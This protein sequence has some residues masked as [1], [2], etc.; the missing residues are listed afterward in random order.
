MICRRAARHHPMGRLLGMALGFLLSGCSA[1]PWFGGEEDPRPP[2]ELEE[3]QPTLKVDRLWVRKIG[4]GTEGRR[5][6]LAPAFQEGQLFIADAK[7][8]VSAIRADDGQVRWQRETGLPYSGGP[9]VAG[10]ALIL[11][12]IDGDLVALSSQ[13][14]QER[15]RIQLASEVLS[16]PKIA[17]ELVIV[18]SLDDQVFG[19]D[20]NT[21]EP[22]WVYAS[23][24]PILSLRGSSAPLI[25]GDAV[26]V[27]LSGGRLV[28]LELATGL[29]EWETT[30]TPPRGRS[31]LARVVD[32]DATPVLDH[33]TL[34][35]CAYNGDLAAVDLESGAV[36]W[37]RKLSAH[38]GLAMADGVLY[39]TDSDDQI[40]AAKPSDGA[41]LWKQD[42]LRYRNLSAPA[43]LGDWLILGD[44]AGYVHWLSR[45]D[46]KLVARQKIADAPIQARPLVVGERVFVYASDGTLAALA[47]H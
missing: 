3:I 41:G 40:W 29:P 33:G 14:G 26:I 12:S 6:G 23:Q 35:V 15:W 39:V 20:L 36:L 5:L 45:A 7:G 8:L 18:H 17:G 27:G 10:D 13:D 34:Y 37:R 19:F 32:L 4:Q 43:V 22:R 21:G 44:L 16:S 28:K 1:I 42:A 9:A 31:E 47:P 11:G 30:V 38:A 24:A 2:A 46:G 25:A